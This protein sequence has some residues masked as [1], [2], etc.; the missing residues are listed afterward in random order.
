M[1]IAADATR[2]M[3][4]ETLHSVVMEAKCEA[5]DPL[6]SLV[7]AGIPGPPAVEG[8]GERRGARA[9]ARRLEVR[10]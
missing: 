9:G 3:T 2:F 6:V 7:G 1:R 10:G 5:V 8:G 4:C